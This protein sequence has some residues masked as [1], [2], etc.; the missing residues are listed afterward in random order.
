MKNPKVF[1]QED[2]GSG[3]NEKMF[4]GHL[5]QKLVSGELGDGLKENRRK[6]D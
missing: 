1:H 4:M 2:L 3:E 6:E 5:S